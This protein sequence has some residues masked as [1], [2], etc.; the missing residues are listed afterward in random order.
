MYAIAFLCF[1]ISLRAAHCAY[2]WGVQ[3]K[4]VR[5]INRA[6]STDN[7]NELSEYVDNVRIANLRFILSLDMWGEKLIFEDTE[8]TKKM[9]EFFCE[10][11]VV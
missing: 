7:V 1:I 10:T 9:K 4:W 3:V 6:L 5:K 8:V 11:S 2:M